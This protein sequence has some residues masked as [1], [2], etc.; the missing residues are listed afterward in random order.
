M[1]IAMSCFALPVLGRPTRR[2]RFNS[3]SV[4]SGRSEKLIRSSCIGFAFFRA[5]PARGN[6]ANRL[7]AIH[8]SPVGIN[9]NK[10]SA[11]DG[12]PQSLESILTSGVFQVFPFECIGIGKHCGRFLERDAMLFK[13]PGG[14]SSIPGEHNLCIYNN[15]HGHV[16]CEMLDGVAHSD[17]ELYR[18]A[19]EPSSWR[20]WRTRKMESRV[21]M[22]TTLPPA[23]TGICCMPT[24]RMRSS[25][26]SAGSSG[27][28]Q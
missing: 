16:K 7:F 3:S 9:Q 2:A 4:E 15:Y 24:V 6:D 28:A 23:I 26:E 18:P 25:K 20:D 1:R 19:R 21:T 8:H 17:I 22:P 14:F 10:D 5:R 12:N 11:L 13:I 27:A